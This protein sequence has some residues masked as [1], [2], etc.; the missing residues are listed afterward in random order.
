MGVDACIFAK[1]ANRYYYFDR[2]YNIQRGYW[3]ADGDGKDVLSVVEWRRAQDAY[4]KLTVEKNATQADVVE[5]MQLNLKGYEHPCMADDNR[6]GWIK[7]ILEFVKT[8]PDDEYCVRTD[9]E[10][11]P[12]W[13]YQKSST[14]KYD[15]DLQKHEEW[16]P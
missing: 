3:A 5:L 10:E 16:E 8:F 6:S 15:P 2:L 9:N 11:P 12:S 7:C 14:W 13:S 1:K 4:D